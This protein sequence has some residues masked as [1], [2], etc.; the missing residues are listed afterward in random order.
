M[1]MFILSEKQKP[2]NLKRVPSALRLLIYA[3]FRDHVLCFKQRICAAKNGSARRSSSFLISQWSGRSSRPL[4]LQSRRTAGSSGT[5]I[6]FTFFLL[7]NPLAS[8]WKTLM[9]NSR[10]EPF[11]A[12][13]SV[14]FGC[15]CCSC[16]FFARHIQTLWS[17]AKKRKKEC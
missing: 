4:F 16:L 11:S 5:F 12:A 15:T 9:M 1:T 14:L 13:G 2:V 10:S 17:L 8:A 7:V 6:C 3:S